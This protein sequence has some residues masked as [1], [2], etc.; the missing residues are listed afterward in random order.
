MEL[1]GNKTDVQMSY[2]QL[3]Q[4]LDKGIDD[5]EAGRVLPLE[6]AFK[7]ITELRNA[8]RNTRI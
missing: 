8:R 1:S 6:D 4:M 2:E 5:M 3:L 7:E